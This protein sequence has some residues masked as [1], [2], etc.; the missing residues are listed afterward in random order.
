MKKCSVCRKMKIVPGCLDDYRQLAHYHYRHSRPGPFEKIFVLRNESAG[1][2]R[3]KTI[4]V[5]VYSMPSP[6]LQLRSTVTDNFF[7]G[8]DRCTQ[9]ELINRNI[10]CISR[11]IIA[12]RF[13]GLGLANRLVRQ[14]MPKMN[15]PIIEA[16]AVM[17]RVN[18]FLE[19]AGMKPYAS[20]P[21]ERFAQLIEALSMIGIEDKDLIDPQKVQRKLTRLTCTETE[22]IDCEIRRFLKGYGSRRNMPPGP[23]RTRYILSRLTDRPVYYIWFNPKFDDNCS[24]LNAHGQ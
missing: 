14:T 18:P 4:G 6:R 20:N 11:V 8:F 19:K 5:I 17:G 22:F 3:K 1:L 15:V 16:M 21:P 2:A 9:L 10:R 23:E 7:G 12:P 24:I 13:R